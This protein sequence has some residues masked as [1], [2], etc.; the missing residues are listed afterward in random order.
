MLISFVRILQIDKEFL[1]INNMLR[2]FGICIV[3]AIIAWDSV[4][5]LP[6]PPATTA[7]PFKQSYD[8][9]FDNVDLDEILGQER[10]LKNY[11]KCLEGAGPCTPDGKMLK[12]YANFRDNTGRYGDRLR[13]MYPETE[14]RFGE[15]DAFLNRQSSRGLGTFGE[16]LR[17]RRDI[18]NRV[19]GG[20]SGK[21]GYK[22]S[23][24]YY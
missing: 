21:Q 20:E 22:L 1:I 24:H 13:Q 8:N 9:K 11:I 5:S 18:S 2:F 6:H 14:I 23:D 16:N 19:L 17:S 12:G 4:K 15:G 3:T 10:L 7:A